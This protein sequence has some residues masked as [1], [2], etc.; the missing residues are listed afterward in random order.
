M[1]SNSKRK[2]YTQRKEEKDEKQEKLKKLKD[3]EYVFQTTEGIEVYSTFDE[4]GLRDDLIK[5]KNIFQ[6]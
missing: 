4:M 2:N 6:Q 1:D 3:E 5:G